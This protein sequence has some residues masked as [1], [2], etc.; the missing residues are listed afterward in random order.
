MA[1]SQH[2]RRSFLAAGAGGV[3]A[4]AGCS[5]A[6]TTRH[7][8][9]PVQADVDGSLADVSM[10]SEGP[11]AVGDGGTVVHRA[12]DDWD[13]VVPDGPGGA[14][15]DLTAVA[16]SSDG[17]HAWFCGS[18]GALGRYHTGRDELKDYSA[19]GGKTSTWVGIDVVGPATG[20]RLRVVNS[21]GELLSARF[22]RQ[23]V[24]WGEVRKPTGGNSITALASGS[25]RSFV[26]SEAD[27]YRRG[28]NRWRP[29]DAPDAGTVRDLAVVGTGV[30]AVTDDGSVLVYNG[31]NWL[32]VSVSPAPLAAID[33]A[34][35]RGLLVGDSGVIRALREGSWRSDD[36]DVDATLRGV[37]LGTERYSAVVVGDGGTILEW[38]R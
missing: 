35:E 26:A 3:A 15:N 27:V 4:L 6:P 13:V 19:P 31:Q 1:P 16:T 11:V 12:A 21:S 23:G 14:S 28:A 2:T 33:R 38:F 17:V 18:S 22:D 32:A 30:E 7:G 37:T 36:A 24:T 25:D 29:L 20:E 5:D 34:G 8:W 10:S 9:I